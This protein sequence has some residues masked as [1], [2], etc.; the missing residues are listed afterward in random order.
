LH[1]LPAPIEPFRVEGREL[2][3]KRDDLTHPL[4]SGNKYRKLYSL[5]QTPREA[6]DAVFSFGGIQSN[7]MLS[8]AALCRLKG[9]RFEYTAKSVPKHLKEDP[10]G[11]Y[12]HALAL[13]M[14]L[15]EVHPTAYDEAVHALKKRFGTRQEK[16]VLIPQGGADPAARDG[17][18]VLAGEIREW[19]KS[20]DIGRL[21]VA[22]PSGTGTTAAYLARAL[23][24]CNVI[25]VAAVGDTA[26][27]QR[28]IEMLMPL[29]KNLTILA[30]KYRFGSLHDDLLKMY[31][32]LKTAGVEFDLIYAPVTWIALLE[33]FEKIEGALLYVH[34]G[35]VSGN[36]T[37]LARYARRR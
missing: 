18:D 21:T 11:N 5:L 32:T 35:G 31:E 13:G 25:T 24:E 33:N 20:T 22:T 16:K 6:I 29:P 9:W 1:V 3:L 14:K 7:A 4:L 37:M 2:Y 19:Q 8:I 10:K 28:Q 26:Y 30:A 12:R 23:P 17:I 34:S 15:T 36:E 27:L